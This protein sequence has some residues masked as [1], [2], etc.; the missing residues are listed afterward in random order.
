M[1]EIQLIFS[2]KNNIPNK[3]L[4]TFVV[5]YIIINCA[6]LSENIL[7]SSRR[8]LYVS[9][10][11]QLTCSSVCLMNFCMCLFARLFDCLLFFASS[12]FN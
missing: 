1:L 7:Y 6:K 5:E 3:F 11:F 12:F 9:V 4:F 8:S 10:F 2:K